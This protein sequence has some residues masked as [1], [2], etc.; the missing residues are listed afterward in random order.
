M[1]KWIL[2]LVAMAFLAGCAHYQE[3]PRLDA[4]NLSEGYRY[5]NLKTPEEDPE[6]SESLFVILTFSGGGTRA[7]ALSFGVL[8]ALR[9]TQIEWEGKS[10]RLLDEVD[11]ISSVSG[12]SFTSAYYGLYGDEIFSKFPKVFL[13]KDIQ[14][15]LILQLLNPVSW[16]KLASPKYGRID[17]AAEYYDKAIFKGKTFES[18]VKK[19]RRPYLLINATDMSVGAQ[20]I[21]TQN[22]FDLLCSNL[23]GVPLAR[24]V[25]ASSN[26]PV[27]FTPLTINNYDNGCG[28]ASPAWVDLAMKDEVVNPPRKH[29]AYL[30]NSYLL[31]G[32]DGKKQRPFLHLLDGGVSDNIGMRGPLRAILSNDPQWSILNKINNGVI[33]KL[34]VITVDARTRPDV[35]YDRKASPPWLFTVL[36]TM[37]TIPLDNFTLDSLSMLQTEFENREQMGRIFKRLN[38]A[39]PQVDFFNVYV[40]FSRVDDGG[41]RETLWNYPTSFSLTRK[42]VNILRTVGGNVLR[43]DGS[44]KSLLEDLR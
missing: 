27:A 8:E 38:V 42:Q 39:I 30:H 24:A 22:T 9:D 14:K 5:R 23:S 26:F 1:K 43:S 33:K 13:Y 35:S 6:N 31:Q 40:G 20:F 41:L 21:F 25:A 19:K 34:V 2:S 15:K 4:F 32:R 3:N 29:R 7:A 16:W 12:G 17:L 44:F 18:L 37:A 10:R 36:S 28:Y 11:V